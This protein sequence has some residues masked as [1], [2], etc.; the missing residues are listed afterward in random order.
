MKCLCLVYICR[1]S[2]TSTAI[3][4]QRFSVKNL[5]TG[6]VFPGADSA[7]TLASFR[8]R[9][10]LPQVHFPQSFLLAARGIGNPIGKLSSMSG[11][12]YNSISVW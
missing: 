12:K 9:G 6:I 4:G 11:I 2:I 1:L 7:V 5:P 10:R 8:N 3:N